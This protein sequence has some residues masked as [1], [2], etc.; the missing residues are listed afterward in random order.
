M[1]IRS[2]LILL[3]I[4]TA[5]SAQTQPTTTTAPARHVV[6]VPPGF[7]TII[8]RGQTLLIEPADEAWV[9]AALAD[10]RP[11][12][13]PSTM[14]ADL[15]SRFDANRKTIAAQMVTDLAIDDPKT[16]DQ[17]FDDKLR[18]TLKRFAE[19]RLPLFYLVT[20]QQRLKQ[21]IQNGWSDPRVY[22][23][24][25]ADNVEI[26]GLL[27]LTIQGEADDILLPVLYEPGDSPLKKEELLADQVRTSQAT[28]IKSV[29]DR[30]MALGQIAFLDFI[31]EQAVEPLRD[32]PDQQWLGVGLMGIL[33]AKYS[34]QITGL[35]G[36]LMV[37]Y[38]ILGDPRNP[39]RPETIDLLHPLPRDQ[40]R[41]GAVYAYDDAF[42]RKAAR[43]VETWIEQAGE[44]NVPKLLVALRKNPPADGIALL[45]LMQQIGGV[46]LTA[47]VGVGK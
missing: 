18:P 8:V 28:L 29:A 37:H 33:S 44:A 26:S 12:S 23:N 25:A 17:F 31:A 14:P 42:R 15:L 16:I 22:Y 45:K 27:S 13:L 2:L 32:K 38:M 21:L 46:D 11:T 47:D 4:A 34:S 3:G 39:I 7:E 6:V 9:R 40:M 10:L 19:L 5:A 35:N 30:A 1:M 20:T 36:A 43:A 41:P 24:R